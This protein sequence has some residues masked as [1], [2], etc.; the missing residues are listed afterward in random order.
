MLPESTQEGVNRGANSE[1]H[2]GRGNGLVAFRPAQVQPPERAFRGARA[3]EDPSVLRL[4]GFTQ[5]GITLSSL[6]FRKT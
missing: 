3:A 6:Y 4:G 2:S 5:D 1:R